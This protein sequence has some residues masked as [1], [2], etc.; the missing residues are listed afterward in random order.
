MTASWS[1]FLSSDEDFAVKQ[2]QEDVFR[3]VDLRNPF[4]VEVEVLRACR[5]YRTRRAQPEV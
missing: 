1:Q 3:C 4:A 5:E 2:W